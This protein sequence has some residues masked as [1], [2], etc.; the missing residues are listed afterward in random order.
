MGIPRLV[1][2]GAVAGLVLFACANLDGLAG[3]P[4]QLGASP[5]N[6]GGTAGLEGGA[7]VT[8]GGVTITP[9]SLDFSSTLCGTKQTA[10]LTLTNAN[11]TDVPYTL[12]S[13]GGSFT[14]EGADANGTVSGTIPA[15][16]STRVTVDANADSPGSADGAI[17]AT[18]GS[19]VTSVPIAM[20]VT[21]A[22]LAITPSVLD[23]GQVRA[24]NGSSPAPVFLQ[25]NGTTPLTIVAFTGADGFSTPTNILLPAG[26]SSEANFALNAGQPS[27]MPVAAIATPVINDAYCGTPPTLT[28][29]GQLVNTSVTVTPGTLDVG[30]TPC[31][32]APTT[33]SG[34]LTLSNFSKTGNVP[35]SLQLPGG[36]HFTLGSGASGTIPQ[37]P[38]DSTPG[39]QAI[40]IGVASVPTTP[41]EY[42]EQLLVTY[43]PTG[44]TQTSSSVTLDLLVT[45]AL[46]SLA[47]TS[48]TAT[49][50]G[51]TNVGIENTGNV[52]I[53]VAYS[54]DNPQSF[55]LESKSDTLQAGQSGHNVQVIY[56]G[57]RNGSN[58]TAH[59]TITPKLCSGASAIANVCNPPV[60]TLTINGLAH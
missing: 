26:S 20:D 40:T 17:A 19:A 3:G 31:G 34:T 37:A 23:F 53:C 56:E 9:G 59:I 16:G 22:S 14:L 2:G 60:P 45:G 5:G 33:P 32:G 28:L 25:N 8:A 21:G 24:E 41:G 12:S 46:I 1:T 48:A 13:A 30:S 29:R 27:A 49:Q 50:F 35:Y 57:Q 55:A 15:H 47:K 42:T 11:G 58:T 54:N 7:P 36:S 38:T 52:P 6:D 51:A 44:G 43:T 10:A 4:G 18:L 39:T